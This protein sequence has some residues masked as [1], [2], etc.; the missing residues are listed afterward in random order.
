MIEAQRQ[1]IREDGVLGHIVLRHAPWL[2]LHP[3][4]AQ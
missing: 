3:A 1:K 4:D 2:Y